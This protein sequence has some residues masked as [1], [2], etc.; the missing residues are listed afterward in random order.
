MKWRLIRTWE[1][2]IKP[3]L[4]TP[5]YFIFKYLL[6]RSCIFSIEFNESFFECLIPEILYIRNMKIAKI[7]LPVIL[8]KLYLFMLIT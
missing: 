4:S 7:M 6:K 2:N 3:S 5:H 1:F 8:V